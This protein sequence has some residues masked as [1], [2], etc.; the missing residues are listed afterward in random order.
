MGRASATPEPALDL[1]PAGRN[2]RDQLAAGMRRVDQ[3]ADARPI[4]LD[5]VEDEGSNRR[6]RAII[7]RMRAGG[8]L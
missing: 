1:P 5:D 8:L 4:C 3:E 6:A 2:L 7:E